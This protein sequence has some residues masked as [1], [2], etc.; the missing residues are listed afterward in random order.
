MAAAVWLRVV[1]R[2]AQRV[3]RAAA[4]G[5]PPSG[6]A[7]HL[8]HCTGQAVMLQDGFNIHLQQGP[9][10][11]ARTVGCKGG[12][13]AAG[14]APAF[15]SPAAA[16]QAQQ[17][18]PGRTVLASLTMAMSTPAPPARCTSAINAGS[19]GVACRAAASSAGVRPS[20]R[21]ASCS[22]MR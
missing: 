18:D 12:E 2:H 16:K 3:E 11:Q 21:A 22:W 4:L 9:A 13:A 14:A 7:V 8:L 5:L 10:G 17:Q 20:C 6:I 19:K 1:R 15:C